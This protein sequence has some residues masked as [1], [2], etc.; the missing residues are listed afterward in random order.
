MSTFDTPSPGTKRIIITL[1]KRKESLPA[2]LLPVPDCRCEVP[3]K[4]KARVLSSENKVEY[5]YQCDRGQGM[6]GFMQPKA[7]AREGGCT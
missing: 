2:Y 6:C 7:V 5:F 3:A 4:L 1:R